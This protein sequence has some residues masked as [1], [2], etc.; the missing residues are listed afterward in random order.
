MEKEILFSKIKGLADCES[1]YNWLCDNQEEINSLQDAWEKCPS[2]HWLFVAIV[3]LKIEKIY[4]QK[5]VKEFALRYLGEKTG[6]KW[7][8][9]MDWKAHEW[10]SKN[11]WN[12]KAAEICRNVVPFGVIEKAFL[13]Q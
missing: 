10:C 8:G 11:E 2:G 6:H 9:H 3:R 13:R 4:I 1:V 7:N 12:G 5:I